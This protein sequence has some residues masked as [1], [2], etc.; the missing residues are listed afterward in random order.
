MRA[1]ARSSHRWRASPALVAITAA[2]IGGCGS[3]GH[4]QNRPRPPSPINLTVYINDQKVSVSPSSAGAGPIVFIVTNQ[5]SRA[6]SV[7]ILPAGVSAG[8]PLADT[9][10][11]SPMAT[12]EV[13]VSLS[14]GAYSVTT[15]SAG[16]TE[17]QA[18]TAAPIQPALLRIGSPRPSSSGQL[19][20]P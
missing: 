2:A 16:G 1:D 9:G 13:K 19:L 3:S 18:V 11:I 8:Q 7:T 6:E 10:P 4:F 15:T 14:T 12:A 5:A 20:I 17:A